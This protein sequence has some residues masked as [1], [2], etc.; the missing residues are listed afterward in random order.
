MSGSGAAGRGGSAHARREHVCPALRIGDVRS[1]RPA[2]A[3]KNLL[4]QARYRLSGSPT[5]LRGGGTSSRSHTHP[6]VRQGAPSGCMS[7]HA[8]IRNAGAPVG[9]CGPR[10]MSRPFPVRWLRL[11]KT[12]GLGRASRWCWS[13]TRPGRGPV[14]PC[15]SLRV[16]LWSFCPLL[17]LRS[18]LQNGSP[19]SHSPLASSLRSMNGKRSK[20]RRHEVVQA[21]IC[22]SWWLTVRKRISYDQRR[23]GSGWHFSPAS[24]PASLSQAGLVDR[25]VHFPGDVERQRPRFCLH[26]GPEPGKMGQALA[27]WGAAPY[28]GVGRCDPQEQGGQD[29]WRGCLH[30]L[31]FSVHLLLKLLCSRN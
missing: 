18:S 2:G 4:E 6:A 16:F 24:L 3:E 29:R 14:R 28:T 23:A 19:M 20:L 10:S 21:P 30:R 8:S 5:R 1:S 15:G 13:S 22:F 27:L 11:P 31:K 25:A 9:C 17:R 12:L 26:E 7:T